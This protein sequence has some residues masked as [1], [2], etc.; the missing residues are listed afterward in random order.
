MR[1]W[2]LQL[3]H[4]TKV[5]I[6]PFYIGEPKISEIMTCNPWSVKPVLASKG[7]DNAFDLFSVLLIGGSAL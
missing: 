6:V 2:V 7:E 5:I 3:F 1:F 4:E